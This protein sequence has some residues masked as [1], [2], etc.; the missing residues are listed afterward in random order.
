MA[1]C[2]VFTHGC[3]EHGF[4]HGGEA[5]ELRSGIEAIIAEIDDGE[6][7]DSLGRLRAIG[8]GL[9]H[10]LQRLLDKTDARDSLA[11]GEA[12]DAE[13]DDEDDESADAVLT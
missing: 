6:D 12:L 11:F 10:D 5:E 9:K 4:I 8:S 3:P 13:N 1:K 7:E 2:T